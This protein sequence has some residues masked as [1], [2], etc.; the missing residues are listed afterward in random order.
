MR[1]F[2]VLSG[3]RFY[4]I[5]I[6]FILLIVWVRGLKGV[7]KTLTDHGVDVYAVSVGI[8]CFI[9]WLRRRHPALGCLQVGYGDVGDL[10]QH[11]LA[12]ATTISHY[13]LFLLAVKKLT[14]RSTQSSTT[15]VWTFSSSFLHPKLGNDRDRWLGNHPRCLIA[16]CTRS[17]QKRPCDGLDFHHWVWGKKTPISRISSLS[18]H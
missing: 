15:A 7:S 13:F 5:I 10:T 17:K 4:I 1:V 6:I 8:I 3:S 12:L 9:M 14:P 2:W 18:T 11:L 16:K